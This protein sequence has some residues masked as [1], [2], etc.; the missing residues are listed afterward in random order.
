MR[1]GFSLIELV[2]AMALSAIIFMISTTLM[3]S[4]MTSNTKNL[5]QEAFE[6][7]KNDL[8][9]E[10]SNAIRWSSSITFSPG[11]LTVDGVVYQLNGGVITKNGE[12]LTSQNVLITSFNIQNLSNSASYASL[13]LDFQLQNKNDPAVK[14]TMRLVVSQR[15]TTI[16]LGSGGPP[17]PP[18]SNFNGIVA[19]QTISGTV[20]I[21]YAADPATTAR[22]SY[23]LDGDFAKW[24]NTDTTSP[25]NVGGDTGWNTATVTP[26]NHSILARIYHL[27]G[28]AA[29]DTIS[30]TVSP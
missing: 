2:V 28:T 27:D 21:T 9:S 23:Y 10:L 6:Q 19:G 1:K 4:I 14:D 17:P 5:R 18:P 30:F 22:V 11:V 8:Q 7:V 26:G 15:K 16:T 13:K 24:I 20:F 29:S 12:A 25:Y 3:M